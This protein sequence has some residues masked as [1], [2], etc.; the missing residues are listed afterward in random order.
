M[1]G[2]QAVVTTLMA[3]GANL[4][5]GIPGVHNLA[6][7]DALLDQPTFRHVLA[8]NEQAASYMANAAGRATRR[9]GICLTTSG[10]GACNALA[11]VADAARESTPMLVL[12]SEIASRFIGQGRGAFHE[13]ADQMG[14]FQ[15]AGA[16]TCRPN[17]VEQIPST[18]NA[19]WVAMTHGRPRPA[20]VGIPEDVLCAEGELA[21]ASAPAPE[22][23]R[24]GASPGQVTTLF[25]RLMAAKRP[26]VYVGGGANRSNASA[27]LTAFVER[28]GLPVVTT[29]HGKGVLSEDHLLSGGVLPL[30]DPTCKD[31]FC[32]A[33]LILAL[34]AGFAQASTA[35]WTTSFSPQLI[36]IDIDGA[37]LG[38]TIPVWMGIVGDAR[39][40]LAQL[41]AAAADIPPRQPSNWA[42]YVV[43]MRR[44]RQRT[45][46][47]QAGAAICEAMRRLL[48]RD[49][50]FV[51]DAP[52]WG[53]WPICHLPVY[54]ADQFLFP[55]HFGTLGYGLGGAIG[56]QAAFPQRRVVATLGD[57]GFVYGIPEL[58]T[59]RQNGLNI[60]IVLVNNGGYESIRCFQEQRYGRARLN[61]VDLMN[62]DFVALA[63]AFDCFGQRAETPEQFESALA[64]A[65]NSGRP[66]LVEITF[67]VKGAPGDYGLGSL[68]TDSSLDD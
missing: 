55:F 52:I 57:G 32:R 56:A 47:G 59:A 61:N 65:L 24:S 40:V 39:S 42:R 23:P 68:G 6:I 37:Q 21:P 30:R 49:A 53:F 14:M 28:L 26:L 13:M 17:T 38:R 9:P 1:T 64:A 67:P 11:G 12:A 46:Q 54:A 31:L 29:V 22:A 2:G 66:A 20:Y 62:P 5:F 43:E 3:N 50:I 60:I 48:P 45:V 15:A 25:S 33:D 34:G 27:E 19:A 41:N 63:R 44:Q 16:W 8:R 36:H 35:F 7:Y 18:I 4:A 58:A 51:G 10:P